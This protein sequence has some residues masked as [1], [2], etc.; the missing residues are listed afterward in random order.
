M[1]TEQICEG[2]SQVLYH[3]TSLLNVSKIVSSNQFQLASTYANDSEMSA[4][5][6]KLFFLSTTRSK[7]GG[8]TMS[9]A[10]PHDAGNAVL[11][12]DGRALG[13]NY[14]GDPVEYW[15]REFLNLA[16]DKNEMEDR[17]YN[18]SPTIPNATKYIKSIHILFKETLN[19][20]A[21]TALIVLKKAGIPV[22]LYQDAKAFV[23]QD[24]RRAK[25]ISDFTLEPAEPA[26]QS[27]RYD[28][29]A[30]NKQT[31]RRD[32]KAGG[33]KEYDKLSY[34]MA[35]WIKLMSTPVANF[36]KLG[37]GS[38]EFVRSLQYGYQAEDAMRSLKADLH[39]ETKNPYWVNKIQPLMKKN[40]L[41]SAKDILEFIIQ[42]WK[43]VAGE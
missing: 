2:L 27:T 28:R 21:R 13:N 33:R 5:S 20:R 23:L 39:N 31:L 6:K 14:T 37:K 12:L 4:G 19:A 26:H 30:V 25:S 3:S 18:D 7:T 41:R 1:K 10:Y 36:D 35:R 38:Q 40:N 11:V 17:V 32:N 43:P 15:G 42:R 29:E 9:N 22:W 24:T 16:P 34:G 8:F